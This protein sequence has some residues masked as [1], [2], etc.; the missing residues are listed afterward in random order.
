MK[1]IAGL[2]NPGKKYEN[3]KHNIGFMV[4][5]LIAKKFDIDMSK[6]KNKGF[7]GSGVVANEKAVLLKPVTYMN[8]SGE[9]IKETMAFYKIS[10]ED[11]I[12]IYDDISLPCGATRIRK[13]GSAGGHNGMKNIIQHLGSDSFTR[14]RVGIGDKPSNWDL[15]DYVLSGFS[16]DEAPLMLAGCERAAKAVEVYIKDGVDAAMNFANTPR[17]KKENVKPEEGKSI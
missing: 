3:T 2:G 17:A 13:K 10:M 7:Q 11:L 12:V 15:A 16:K 1:L 8:L 14:V 4:V 9:S 6:I 5:D